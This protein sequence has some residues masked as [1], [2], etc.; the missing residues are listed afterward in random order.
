MRS[1]GERAANNQMAPRE[2]GNR[3]ASTLLIDVQADR[4]VIT[5]SG[6]G[7]LKQVTESEWVA[8]GLSS[9][10]IVQPIASHEAIDFGDLPAVDCDEVSR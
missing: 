8:E 7:A 9:V 6:P 3:M 1:T 10:A 2:G 5:S 4:V